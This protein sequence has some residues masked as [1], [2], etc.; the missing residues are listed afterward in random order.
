MIPNNEMEL[1]KQISEIIKSEINA[2]DEEISDVFDY[3]VPAGE[4]K[5]LWNKYYQ[6]LIDRG[7]SK[8]TARK[9]TMNFFKGCHNLV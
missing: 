9:K 8:E 3:S 5:K 2:T 6:N 7:D 4:Q 1:K